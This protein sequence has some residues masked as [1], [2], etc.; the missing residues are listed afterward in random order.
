MILLVVVV[1]QTQSSMSNQNQ[2]QNPIELQEKIVLLE[3]YH[4]GMRERQTSKI[5]RLEKQIEDLQKQ[6]YDLTSAVSI[7]KKEQP[8]DLST[9][10][11][12]TDDLGFDVANGS[13]L[14][15]NAGADPRPVAK[16]ILEMLKTPP[17][18]ELLLTMLYDV[19]CWFAE[20]DFQG[21]IGYDENEGQFALHKEHDWQ[22]KKVREQVRDGEHDDAIREWLAEYIFDNDGLP[23]GLELIFN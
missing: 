9:I 16:Q 14:R 11:G 18:T 10:K 21:V 7:L 20:S 6:N 4:E 12:D 2:N 1:S 17:T 23:D 19:T 3:K 13:I 22:M 8:P 5:L 15:A